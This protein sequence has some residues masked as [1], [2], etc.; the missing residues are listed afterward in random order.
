MCFA[1]SYLLIA[2]AFAEAVVRFCQLGQML[3]DAQQDA[4]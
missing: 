1:A 4:R 2:T 3:N